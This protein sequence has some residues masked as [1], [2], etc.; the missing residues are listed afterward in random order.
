MQDNPKKLLT[1][2]LITI[3]GIAVL[4]YV[5][6]R[7]RDLLRGPS[8]TLSS[9]VDGGSF[10]EPSVILEGTVKNTSELFINDR[11]VFISEEGAFSEELLLL[12]GYTIM[13]VVARD[14]FGK[15]AMEELRL[16][17]Q[18]ENLSPQKPATIPDPAAEPDEEETSTPD[19]LPRG[20][21]EELPITN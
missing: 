6:Y 8:I 10:T 17:L 9:P 12:P 3:I 11:K 5:Y 16:Y 15:E 18:Q 4:G 21:D 1:I 2:A 14:K 7:S 19:D 13:T 20:D